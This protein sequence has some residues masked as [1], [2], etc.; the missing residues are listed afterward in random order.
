MEHREAG[1]VVVLVGV[2]VALVAVIGVLVVARVGGAAS[3][4]A[5]A[6]TAA[7][8]AALAG[9]VEGEDEA[10]EV[11]ETNQGELEGY[12]HAGDEVEVTVR[13]GDFRATSRAR[14]GD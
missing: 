13:V 5:R 4:R 3:E 7:D 14:L 10:R 6:H 11:A 9:A 2:V 1:Q 8:A 12:V